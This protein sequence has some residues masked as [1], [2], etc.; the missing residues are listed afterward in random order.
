MR[1]KIVVIIICL[2]II[3]GFA[4]STHYVSKIVIQRGINDIELQQ[5]EQNMLQIRSYLRTIELRIRQHTIDWAHW[6]DAYEFMATRDLE[7]IY[8]NFDRELLDELHIMAAA[9]YDTK[10]RL[11]TFADGSKV[12][13]DADWDARE[14]NIF[15]KFAA[16]MAQ[17]DLDSL[18]G[19]AAV[20]DEGLVIAAQKVYDSDKQK[21]ARGWLVMAMPLD[22]YFLEDAQKITQLHFSILPVQAFTSVNVLANPETGFKIVNAGDKLH[23]YSICYDVF[24]DSA[25]C[26]ELRVDR[27]IAILGRQI[28]NKNFWFI[29]CFGCLILLTGICILLYAQ[30]QHVKDVIAYK[31][32][33]D[34]L[35]GLPNK[36]N[37]SNRLPELARDADA[38][39]AC[40]G[41]I[42]LDLDRF[43]G[44]ND[45]LGHMF[46]DKL[47]CEAAKR[48]T[49]LFPDGC[50]A[51]QGGDEF[52]I[53]L[54]AAK[55]KHIIA[56]TKGMHTIV[57]KPFNIDGKAVYLG[58]SIGVAIYPDDGAT[59]GALIR[60]AELAMYSS[61]RHGRNTFVSFKNS[62]EEAAS[63]KLHMENALYDAVRKNS[64][65]V[66]YQPKVDIVAR[67]VVGCEALV[68]WQISDGRWIPPSDFIPLAEEIGLVTDID[69]FVL[70]A[71]CRQALE[72]QRRGCPPVVIAVNMSG[73]SI[74][75]DGFADR[76]IAILE[77]EKTPAS[78]INVEITETSLISN[79]DAAFSAISRLYEAGILIALDDFGTGYSS[80]QYLSAMP[81]SFLK[82]DKKFVDNI[83]SGKVTGP[84]LVKSILALA[85]NLGMQTVSEGVEEK[86]QMHFLAANGAR[87]IQGY[88]FSKPL[89][90]APFEEFV[91]KQE[92]VIASVLGLEA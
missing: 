49:Q 73:K 37:F 8:K 42:F 3:S 67:R 6:D 23:V 65:T 57:Q 12:A 68:R 74:L 69:M 89:D 45:S 63:N 20:R 29:L 13:R 22:Q 30:H 70:R 52:L 85:A 27:T 40:V 91:K 26:I 15:T 81:I 84:P 4:A 5:A 46:G 86:R 25:F 16:V 54:V 60:R 7:F 19:Y 50:V 82:V 44:V 88:L 48:L 51:R 18:E 75:A 14:R 11:I 78:L 28:A 83:Y 76:V 58:A 55:R 77:E 10:G 2:C 71:A 61:K 32:L 72:W 62:M 21:A 53:A 80:L 35:T 87:I 59:P 34:A 24:G 38:H 41:V 9:F 17:G 43:K 31:S 66:Q 33:H 39:G 1:R 36:L 47:L 56:Q 90:A 64:F 79:L 92:A